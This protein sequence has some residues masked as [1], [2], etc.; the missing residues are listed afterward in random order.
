[1]T[2]L[3]PAAQ[4]MTAHDIAVKASVCTR[5]VHRWV[6]A[7]LLPAP[8]LRGGKTARWSSRAIDKALR[9]G[10]MSNPIELSEGE[11]EA[12]PGILDG[13]ALRGES[14]SEHAQKSLCGL[15]YSMP[16]AARHDGLEVA[17]R[18]D[19]LTRFV[20]AMSR[21]ETMEAIAASARL[22]ELLEDAKQALQGLTP[23]VAAAP[24]KE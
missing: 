1:M 20:R 11:R 6:K 24:Q 17:E 22:Q 21:A 10:S 9:G 7:G 12:L 15:F 2:T 4:L 19:L 8:V 16:Y 3:T 13:L 18:V 23:G 14:L 5:T